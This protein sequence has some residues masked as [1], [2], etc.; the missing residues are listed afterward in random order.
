M[1]EMVS[2]RLGATGEVERRRRKAETVSALPRGWLR[3]SLD[4]SRRLRMWALIASG[5]K[6]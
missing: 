1:L 3:S 5:A 2:R 6:S 4:G